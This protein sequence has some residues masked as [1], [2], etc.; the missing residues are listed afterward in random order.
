MRPPPS[1]KGADQ[2]IDGSW[3]F[4]REGPARVLVADAVCSQARDRSGEAGPAQAGPR[5]ESP[6]RH[7][8]WRRMPVGLDPMALPGPRPPAPRLLAA[9]LQRKPDRDP[10]V[11]GPGGPW[12]SAMI[13]APGRES[14]PRR[15]QGLRGA[16]PA[17]IDHHHRTRAQVGVRVVS[18]PPP[19]RTE[20]AIE[21]A[22]SVDHGCLPALGVPSLGGQWQL[23]EKFGSVG[24]V[25]CVD[26]QRPEAPAP[27][28]AQAAQVREQPPSGNQTAGR[29]VRRTPG[30]D[31]ERLERV[32]SGHGA[33]LLR[34]RLRVPERETEVADPADLFPA[35][36]GRV[37]LYVSPRYGLEGLDGDT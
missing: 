12:P 15:L 22:E 10:S 7:V 26:R 4:V 9:G 23:C 17:C 35:S 31:M 5:L 16:R 13:A 25:P 21:D 1:L 36:S 33:V 28:R 14:S 8:Q 20:P 19:L 18:R 29:F 30:E 27:A 32:A 34:A 2:G 6:D 37:P 24:P 11:N 3:C